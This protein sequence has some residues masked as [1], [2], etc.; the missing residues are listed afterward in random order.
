MVVEPL[1]DLVREHLL[2]LSSQVFKVSKQRS[3]PRVQHEFTPF[4]HAT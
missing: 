3:Q 4:I 2:V 1:L